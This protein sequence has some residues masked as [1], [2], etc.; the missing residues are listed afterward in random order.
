MT[1]WTL[2]VAIVGLAAST[3]Y[4]L[5]KAFHLGL[6]VSAAL[7]LL[8]V[9]QFGSAPVSTPG[10]LGVYH[11]LTVVVLSAFSIDRQ[12]AIGYAIVLYTVALL[13]KIVLGTIIICA[14]G[15]GSWYRST[16]ARYWRERVQP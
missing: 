10:N 3:N 4:L 12:A 11:Y 13:P 16:F 14:P 15:Y 8:V 1:L 9:L 7:L 2:T 6:P 5:F